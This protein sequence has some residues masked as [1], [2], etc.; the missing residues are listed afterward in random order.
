[1]PIQV[2]GPDG[3]LLEFPDDTP[4]ETMRAAMQKR[5]PPT[6]SGVSASVDS[7]GASPEGL[8]AGSFSGYSPE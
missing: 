7:T 4:R 2:E 5:Y 3:Q 8:L 6:F 1:M